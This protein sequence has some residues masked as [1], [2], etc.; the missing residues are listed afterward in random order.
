[1]TQAT[2]ATPASTCIRLKHRLFGR[3]VRVQV[4][5]GPDFGELA[6]AGE[7]TMH[8]IDFNEFAEAIRRGCSGSG[9]RHVEIVDVAK[10]AIAEAELGVAG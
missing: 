8:P 4:L 6:W 5:V 2:H 9:D 10:A 1:M 7:L 3:L